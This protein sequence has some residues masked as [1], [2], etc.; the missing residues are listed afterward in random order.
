MALDPPSTLDSTDYRKGCR[1]HTFRPESV[2]RPHFSLESG[3]Y[4]AQGVSLTNLEVPAERRDEERRPALRVP[5][6]H[7]RA[8]LS[9]V[10]YSRVSGRGNGR[11][12]GAGR[13]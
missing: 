4:L 3:Q 11:G 10:Q 8:V 12:G 13:T 7:R 5:R 9:T 2:S 6:V 1:A